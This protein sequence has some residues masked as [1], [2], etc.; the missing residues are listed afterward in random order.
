MFLLLLP[1]SMTMHLGMLRLVGFL[2]PRLSPLWVM[3]GT[4]AS[5]GRLILT[6]FEAIRETE[7]DE[8]ITP[9]GQRRC[10]TPAHPHLA[11][12]L[13]HATRIGR[14]IVRAVGPCYHKNIFCL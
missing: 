7:R 10:A 2:F 1:V 11:L 5:R 3:F 6:V 14:S 9:A 8:S 12:R 4:A 13:T